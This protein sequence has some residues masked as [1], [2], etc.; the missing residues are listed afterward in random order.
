MRVGRQRKCREVFESIDAAAA[1]VVD[2][3]LLI[4]YIDALARDK[5]I[6]VNTPPRCVRQTVS[7]VVGAGREG[8]R[9]GTGIEGKS[10]GSGGSRRPPRGR[11]EKRDSSRGREVNTTSSDGEDESMAKYDGDERG[12]MRG[13]ESRW[14]M[15][16]AVLMMMS[17]HKSVEEVRNEV[18]LARALDDIIAQ[19][20]SSL[21]VSVD[22][23]T[24]RN[25]SPE[26]TNQ[27]HSDND[28]QE[29]PRPIYGQYRQ[30]GIIIPP[31]YPPAL[32]EGT[33]H[34]ECA[35]TSPLDEEEL[36]LCEYI[37]QGDSVWQNDS[38]VSVLDDHRGVVE[39]TLLGQP[40]V[41]PAVG[42][43]RPLMAVGERGP[44]LSDG[45][46]YSR[47]ISIAIEDTMYRE[48]HIRPRYDHTVLPTLRIEEKLNAL[49]D[50]ENCKHAIEDA[51][52]F[53][54]SL[55]S[56]VSSALAKWTT[57]NR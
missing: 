43:R 4:A 47:N 21:S 6:V 32:P 29:M 24:H 22:H 42:G 15:K 49:R 11:G 39:N 33:L 35:T 41:D 20:S 17:P 34:G 48:R 19:S 18:K 50:K 27:Y 5:V 57:S 3:H 37:L 2:M 9:G 36:A 52:V 56:E 31:Q 45:D 44:Q 30:G 1:G 7:G 25:S 40:D 23:D 16:Q 14:D 28:T 53:A 26:T 8:I 46:D 54:D 38:T 12:G 55:A 10:R 13:G 51:Y